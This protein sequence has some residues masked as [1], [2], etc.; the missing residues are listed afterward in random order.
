MCTK[1]HA[2][3]LLGHV[4]QVL[5]HLCMVVACAARLLGGLARVGA[6]QLGSK[7]RAKRVGA[8]NPGQLA[9]VVQYHLHLHAAPP[10]TL[11]YE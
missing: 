1:A 4:L 8:S 2:G 9:P 11:P 3:R 6:K 7:P 10:P 5:Y